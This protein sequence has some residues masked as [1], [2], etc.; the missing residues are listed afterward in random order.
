MTVGQEIILIWLKKK[1][2]LQSGDIT[3]LGNLSNQYFDILDTMISC[4][5]DS[6]LLLWTI[7]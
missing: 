2:D 4:L 6:S 5:N 1:N 7:T 3:A